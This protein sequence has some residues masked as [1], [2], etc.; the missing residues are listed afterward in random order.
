MLISPATERALHGTYPIKAGFSYR[1]EPKEDDMRNAFRKLALG[2]A[3]IVA[4]LGPAI[5]GADAAYAAHH[6]RGHHWR[7]HHSNAWVP[8]FFGGLALGA[9]LSG[10]Y[11]PYGY[12]YGYPYRC[13][14][15]HHVRVC[16]RY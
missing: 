11:Y 14:Y 3:T 7:H 6:H 2:G 9:A 1:E 15:R 12:P 8:G 13:Y 16:Y 5:A 4:V 10:S